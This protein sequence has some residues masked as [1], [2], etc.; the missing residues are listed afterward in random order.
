MPHALRHTFASRLVRKG[1]PLHVVSK[2]LGH[3]R[4]QET[5]RYAHLCEE[6][7]SDAVQV[8]EE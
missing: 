7:L 5:D 6:N 2:L 4:L 1:V 3:K 8:L